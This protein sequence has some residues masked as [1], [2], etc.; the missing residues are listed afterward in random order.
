[1]NNFNK[2]MYLI[3][4]TSSYKIDRKHIWEFNRC[5]IY[6]K[7]YLYKVSDLKGR[8]MYEM[9]KDNLYNKFNLNTGY[10]LK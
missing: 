1:M 6:L 9:E 3:I 2:V 5:D 10:T 8:M 4:D 7:K